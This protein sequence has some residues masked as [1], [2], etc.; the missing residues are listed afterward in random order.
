MLLGV[1]D[2]ISEMTREI[3]GNGGWVQRLVVKMT[4]GGS[5]EKGRNI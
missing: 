1:N 2:L 5:R 3:R 4:G